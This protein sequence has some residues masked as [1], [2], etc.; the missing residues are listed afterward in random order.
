MVEKREDI[1]KI[2]REANEYA[3]TVKEP[4]EQK[5]QKKRVEEFKKES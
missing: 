2:L 5:E 3:K 1:E 4:Q